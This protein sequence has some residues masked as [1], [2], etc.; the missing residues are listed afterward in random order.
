MKT[1]ATAQPHDFAGATIHEPAYQAYQLLHWA[2]V[3]VPIIAGADKFFMK[4]T[5]WTMYL[6]EPLRK[7]FGTANNFM[8]I[9]GAIEIVA[10]LL[11]AFKPKL[12]AFIVG[13]W[14]IGIIC[15]LLLLGGFYDIAL[16]DF[17]LCLG[18]FA[19]WRLSMLYDHPHVSPPANV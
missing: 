15:N 8:M 4:L 3:I 6:W 11:I 10:G 17:G 12:G 1:I 18:A 13:L 7:V 19:L 9:A 2:F 14:L 16:R 5:D